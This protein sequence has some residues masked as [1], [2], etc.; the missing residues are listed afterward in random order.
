LLM[1]PSTTDSP[2]CGILI[3]VPAMY[4]PSILKD[5]KRRPIGLKP[6]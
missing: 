4:S 5:P 6:A 1:V 2:S 3:S